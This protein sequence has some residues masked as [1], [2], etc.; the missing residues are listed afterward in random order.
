METTMGQKV[1]E[2]KVDEAVEGVFTVVEGHELEAYTA[3]GWQIVSVLPETRLES[4]QGK[5][6]SPGFL[7][8]MMKNGY[9]SLPEVVDT[10]VSVPVSIHKYLL[11]KGMNTKLDELNGALNA[12]AQWAA[13]AKLEMERLK[14]F[15]E[16]FAVV[17][18]RKDEEIEL[19]L[20]L[21][22]E[23]QDRESQLRRAKEAME[24]DIAAIRLAI[25]E[26]RMKEIISAEADKPF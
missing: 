6:V 8:E 12:A 16:E 3:H 13:E 7:G 23:S 24:H 1:A 5:G 15:N 4:R 25:G 18:K 17:S 20:R 2:L 22:R 10:E 14:K 21:G 19:R 26:E 11:R 9:S